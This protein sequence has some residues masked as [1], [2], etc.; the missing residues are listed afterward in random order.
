YTSDASFKN[1]VVK[2]KEYKNFV[3]KDDLIYLKENNTEVL[4]I[5]QVLVKGHS[6]HELIISKAHSIL[7]H[8]SAQKTL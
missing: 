3:L 2:L 8:L 7:A 6:I 4:C 1:V 5:P